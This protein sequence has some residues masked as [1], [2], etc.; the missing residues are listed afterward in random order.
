MKIK[1]QKRNYVSIYEEKW[2]SLSIFKRGGDN[3]SLEQLKFIY[4]TQNVEY[5]QI[6]LNKH[7]PVFISLGAFIISIIPLI[8]DNVLKRDDF[9]SLISILFI[10]FIFLILCFLYFKSTK[11]R[12]NYYL[13]NYISIYIIE[14]LQSMTNEEFEIYDQFVRNQGQNNEK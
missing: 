12:T 13:E 6:D 1:T 4:K 9:L 2:N 8:S 3:E 14:K 7:L 10:L 5:D 11:L